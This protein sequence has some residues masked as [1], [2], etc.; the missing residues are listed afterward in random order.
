MHVRDLEQGLR[1]KP[2]EPFVMRLSSGE[3][4]RADHSDAAVPGT[5][6]VLVIRKR[7]GRLAGF[8]HVS[9]FHVVR[10]E[11]ANGATNGR[12]PKNKDSCSRSQPRRT[13]E[14]DS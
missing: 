14:L 11:P 9:L 5:N 2:I 12:S 13:S 6:A 10:I 1:A 7:G 3:K 4:I 8:S